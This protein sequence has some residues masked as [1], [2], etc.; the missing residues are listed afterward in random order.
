MAEEAV[1]H[2][3]GLNNVRKC[4]LLV[5]ID[6]PFLGASPDGLLSCKCCGTAVLEAKCPY[7][8]KDQNIKE[9]Y[10]KVDFLE[11][12]DGNLRLKRSHR[13]YSQL[14]TEIALKGCSYGFIIVWTMVD[15]F[16]EKIPFDQNR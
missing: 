13:Y 6:K 16:I 3:G 11:V 1:K 7:S 5:K 15:Y 9:S 8:I 12:C 4:G 2:D 14:T 10:E